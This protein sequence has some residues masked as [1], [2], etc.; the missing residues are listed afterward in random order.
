MWKPTTSVIRSWVRLLAK[1]GPR[2]SRSAVAQRLA[3]AVERWGKSP[4][5]GPAARLG[6]SV[7]LGT[8]NYVAEERLKLT[9][10]IPRLRASFQ[11][12]SHELAGRRL[13]HQAHPTFA[14]AHE[15]ITGIDVRHGPLRGSD[16]TIRQ[17][18]NVCSEGGDEGI[19]FVRRRARFPSA[20][21]ASN[22]LA[23]RITSSTR[24]RSAGWRPTC[25]HPT[26]YF[27]VTNRSGNASSA[28]C[29]RSTFLRAAHTTTC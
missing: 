6:D 14:F 16:H 22:R 5:A 9:L 4:Q 21:L 27:T 23:P 10:A 29:T 12:I 24:R 1:P 11:L 8:R 20:V 25:R 13:E 2:L 26:V 7:S 3:R 19:Q 18:R 17:S 28:I 15:A